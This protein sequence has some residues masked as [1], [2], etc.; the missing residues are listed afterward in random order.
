MKAVADIVADMVV[1]KKVGLCRG[2]GLSQKCRQAIQSQLNQKPSL[3]E[4]DEKRVEEE[5]GGEQIVFHTNSKG[6]VKMIESG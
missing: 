6:E 4:I 1:S 3:A 2:K 5:W